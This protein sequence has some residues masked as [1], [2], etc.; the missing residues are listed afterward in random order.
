MQ[1]SR[2]SITRIIIGTERGAHNKITIKNQ[3]KKTNVPSS[4]GI[5]PIPNVSLRGKTTLINYFQTIHLDFEAI[6]IF[7]FSQIL[8]F[9]M[10]SLA[11]WIKV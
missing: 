2:A 1:Y 9:H 11:K 10:F 6:I 7:F 3:I 4:S 5:Y 8:Y